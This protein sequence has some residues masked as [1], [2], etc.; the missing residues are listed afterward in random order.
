MPDTVLSSSNAA[1]ILHHH[2]RLSALP[3]NKET[4]ACMPKT[5]AALSHMHGPQDCVA[6]DAAW[7]KALPL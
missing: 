4:K 7:P 1:L 3:E 6:M 2:R 5:N